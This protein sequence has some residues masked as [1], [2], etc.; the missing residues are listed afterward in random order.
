MFFSCPES[1]FL[2]P[3]SL[4][5]AIKRP[6]S[7]LFVINDGSLNQYS[8][9]HKLLKVAFQKKIPS[10]FDVPLFQHISSSSSDF[11]PIISKIASEL[12]YQNPSS[13]KLKLE[14]FHEGLLAI[15]L[16]LCY[17]TLYESCNALSHFDFV[18]FCFLINQV[19]FED[20]R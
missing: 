19:L 8:K 18:N 9:N 6:A 13:K 11:L 12:L 14:E 1:C 16:L 20:R 17:L 5:P 15:Y 2:H 10:S 4:S 7:H 3:L